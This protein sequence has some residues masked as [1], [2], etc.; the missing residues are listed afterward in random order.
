[1][2]V[3]PNYFHSVLFIWVVFTLGKVMYYLALQFSTI[4]FHYL[5]EVLGWHLSDCSAWL[6]K[7]HVKWMISWVTARRLACSLLHYKIIC[8]PMLIFGKHYF[9]C[10]DLRKIEVPYRAWENVT[11]PYHCN[12]RKQSM[13]VWLFTWNLC[14]SNQIYAVYWV[15]TTKQTKERT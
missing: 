9:D 10:K 5:N 4:S 6:I 7:S 14:I 1:M 11:I 8:V 2:F 15:E 3:L 13:T 12:N